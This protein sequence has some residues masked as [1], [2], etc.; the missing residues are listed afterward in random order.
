MSNILITSGPTRE[1]LDPVRYLSNGSSG[2]MGAALARACLAR[3]QR[4]RVVSG[5]V[6]VA[7]PAEA[8]VIRVTTTEE[9]FQAAREVFRDADGLIAAAAP[10]DFRPR[11]VSTTKIAK[12]AGAVVVDLV[13]TIDIAEN[14]GRVKGNR[15]ILGFALETHDHRAHALAKLRRKHFDWIAVND[16]QVMDATETA[17]ELW[18]AAEELVLSTS[19]DKDKVAQALVNVVLGRSC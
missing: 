4:V 17:V 8:E 9:M 15:W 2:R 16:A 18:N 14:L 6:A 1:P 5:P 3:G 11:H 19:G 10:C 13:E 7:Y 12:S